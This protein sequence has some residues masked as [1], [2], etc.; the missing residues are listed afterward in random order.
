MTGPERYR[1]AE[2]LLSE[3]DEVGDDPPLAVAA[4]TELLAWA[5]LHA[6]LAVA[7]A[8]AL[9]AEPSGLPTENGYAAMGHEDITA[10]KKVA[11]TAPK[12]YNHG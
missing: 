12:R 8:T 7:A 1:A 6:T 10:W 4:R 2:Q 9:A 11:G 5:Q 3:V